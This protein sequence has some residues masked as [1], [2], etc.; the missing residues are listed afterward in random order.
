MVVSLFWNK[1]YGIDIAAKGKDNSADDRLLTNMFL[2][3]NLL[4]HTVVGHVCV[5]L[6]WLCT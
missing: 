3:T 6:Q 5:V 1:C 4:F 2:N